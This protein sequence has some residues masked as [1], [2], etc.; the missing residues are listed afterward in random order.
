V[1]GSNITYQNNAVVATGANAEVLINPVQPDT[2]VVFNNMTPTITYAPKSHTIGAGS[3]PAEIIIDSTLVGLLN[4]NNF[5]T[6]DLNIG[7]ALQSL[8]IN[9]DISLLETILPSINFQSQSYP[10]G[11]S[12]A[13]SIIVG[14]TAYVVAGAQNGN[15]GSNTVYTASVDSNGIMGQFGNT[16]INLPYSIG[17][18]SLSYYNGYIYC[19]YPNATINASG[20]AVYV[21]YG[22][23]DSN[24]NISSWTTEAVPTTATAG[25]SAITNLSAIAFNGYLYILTGTASVSAPTTPID[26]AYAPISGNGSIGTWTVCT[27]IVAPNGITCTSPIVINNSLYIIAGGDTY[28]DYSPVNAGT[29]YAPVANCYQVNIDSTTGAVT[30]FTLINNLPKALVAGTVVASADYVY[31]LGGLDFAGSINDVVYQCPITSTGLGTWVATT[32]MLPDPFF[33]GNAFLTSSGIYTVGGIDGAAGATGSSQINYIPIQNNVLL[34]WNKRYTL[35]TVLS[36]GA[37]VENSG[38]IYVIGGYT[39]GA[40]TPSNAVYASYYN[41]QNGLGSWNGVPSLPVALQDIAAISLNGYIYVFGGYNGTAAVNTIYQGTIDTTTNLVSSWTELTIVL[42]YVVGAMAICATATNIYLIGGWNQG[43]N[44]GVSSTIIIP[45]NSDSTLG[46][47]Y[48]SAQ[49]LPAITF[50]GC[51]AVMNG[52]I[53]F[54]SYSASP[55]VLYSSLISPTGDIYSWGDTG[56][57]LPY[58]AAGY[59]SP[60]LAVYEDFMYY[61]AG[62]GTPNN[63]IYQYSVLPNSISNPYPIVAPVPTSYSGMMSIVMGN[64]L[65]IMGGNSASTAINNIYYATLSNN[66]KYSLIPTNQLSALPDNIFLL[67]N[68][69]P[70]GAI[71]NNLTAPALQQLTVSDYA[72]DQA[73][74]TYKYNPV[75]PNS[76]TGGSAF[77]GIKNLNEGDQVITLSGVIGG[78][79]VA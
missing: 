7:G 46:A 48:V 29:N 57:N 51:A 12:Y 2:G 59:G 35:P 13:S 38:Y 66:N 47:P 70:V 5:N 19:V 52:V 62:M 16:G 21:S 74:I 20:G 3:T 69:T 22:V 18:S 25:S 79:Q 30:G 17:P 60:Q 43:T 71:D 49:Q 6:V 45:I 33:Y 39:T 78:T 4:T 8:V 54:S 77:L 36:N 34:T 23:T 65:F 26:V 27:G 58:T 32:T 1:T 10:I 56:Q 9:K 75:F 40:G 28:P 73:I 53:Y 15:G 41:Q 55:N 61:I 68:L 44:S 63:Y 24:G 64:Q 50:Y 14:N 11:I 67:G 72:V 31:Y 42:P 37:V 76:G